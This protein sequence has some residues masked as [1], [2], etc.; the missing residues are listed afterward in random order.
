MSQF[1]ARA[2]LAQALNI[3]YQA[4]RHRAERETWKTVI[5]KGPSGKEIKVDITSI[6]KDLQI[7]YF[8]ARAASMPSI[9]RQP[10][11]LAALDGIRPAAKHRALVK[12]EILELAAQDLIEHAFTHGRRTEAL[13]TWL[14]DVNMGRLHP[15]L[16][17][18]AGGPINFRTFYRWQKDSQVKGDSACHGFQPPFTHSVFFGIRAF[19]GRFF[20]H[21]RPGHSG[22]PGGNNSW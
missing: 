21:G 1:I 3:S 20:G 12:L 10:E 6:P 22:R 2:E 9:A 19:L 8:Q 13:K 11:S 17:A 15:G 14:A 4:L 7:R 18:R 16:A 5:E